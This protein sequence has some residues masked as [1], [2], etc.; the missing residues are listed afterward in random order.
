MRVSGCGTFFWLVGGEVTGHCSRNLVFSLKLPCSV[1]IP[2][3][4]KGNAKECSNCH[5]IALISHTSKKKVKVAYHVRLFATPW[6]I[7]FSRPEY[8]SE[9]LFPSPG[10]LPNPRL[11]R[12]KWIL[13]HQ[14]YQ[15]SPTHASKVVFKIL[16]LGFN[17][18]WIKNLQMFKLDLEKGEE[19]EIKLLTSI[20]S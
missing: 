7:E 20:G 10:D 3:Q 9:Y 19:P 13:Y 1:F 4:K 12:C 6:T 16:K 8:W 5:T 2:I 14:S 11:L 17:V 15:G 18:T